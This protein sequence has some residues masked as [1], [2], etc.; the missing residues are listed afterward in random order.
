MAVA[1]SI[2]EQIFANVKTALEAIEEGTT[3]HYDVDVVRA[4]QYV[5]ALK[6]TKPQVL[7]IRDSSESLPAGAQRQFGKDSRTLPVFILIAH[8]D[9]ESELD[10]W[11]RDTNRGTIRH[12]RIRDVIVALDVDR[13]RG[14]LAHSQEIADINKDFDEGAG[15][16]I[17]AELAVEIGF[18]SE[19]DTP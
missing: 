12:R 1:E 2:E 3:Y 18:E 16:W 9:T 15:A 6:P 10:P 17:L 14:A 13:S 7:I 19:L 11:L 8:Y 4:D 5:N